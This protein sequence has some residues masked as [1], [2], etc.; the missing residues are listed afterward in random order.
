MGITCCLKLNSKFRDDNLIISLIDLMTLGGF[1]IL[2]N[3]N[4]G[5]V[6]A[7]SCLLS[8]QKAIN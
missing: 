5:V 3:M 2:P 4:H 6:F 7:F 1:N 8:L